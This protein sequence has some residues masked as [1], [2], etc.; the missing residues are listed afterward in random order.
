MTVDI[1]HINNSGDIEIIATYS[2]IGKKEALKNAYLQLIEKRFDVWNY[3][4][5][6]VNIREGKGTYSIFYGDNNILSVKK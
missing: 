6:H 1:F 4:K 5:Y 2:D 3:E